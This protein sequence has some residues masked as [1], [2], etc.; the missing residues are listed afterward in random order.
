MAKD[1]IKVLTLIVAI[2]FIVTTGASLTYAS[3]RMGFEVMEKTEELYE[4]T[5]GTLNEPE[6][7]YYYIIDENEENEIR[8]APA[9][10]ILFDEVGGNT[11]CLID[12]T[13]N[14][15]VEVL[16]NTILVDE[17]TQIEY[18]KVRYG[19]ITGYTEECILNT[20]P[21]APAIRGEGVY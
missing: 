16:D 20:E 3:T 12:G 14:E 5:L 19:N 8:Y 18:V 10:L 21:F 4:N 9:N 2:S 17:R 7:N 11:Y 13:F 6:I 15:K 1:L